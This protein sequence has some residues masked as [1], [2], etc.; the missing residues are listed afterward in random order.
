MK[1][2]FYNSIVRLLLLVILF[3]SSSLIGQN[4]KVLSDDEQLFYRNLVRAFRENSIEKAKIN[5][6]D[7]ERK[8]IEKAAFGRDSAI[9]LALAMNGNPHTFYRSQGRYIFGAS[10]PA[11][12]DTT[13]VLS[14][15]DVEKRIDLDGIAI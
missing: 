13:A 10:R 3:S 12:R 6:D 5:W 11:R 1:H 9:I 2:H 4:D 15:K 14:C 7:F 8:V